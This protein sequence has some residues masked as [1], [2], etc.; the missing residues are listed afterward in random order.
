VFI[1]KK[2][3]KISVLGMGLLG[4]SVTLA[5]RRSKFTAI[6]AGYSHR[7]ST[8]EKAEALGVADV[9]Y[10]DLAECVADADIVILASP[11]CTF[12]QIFAEIGPHLKD[13]CIVTDVGST[14]IMPHIWAQKTLP[15][16]VHYVGSHPIAG[17]EK[18][19]V[20]YARDDL[21]F[22]ARCIITAKAA[23]HKPS[24]KVLQKFWAELGCNVVDLTPNMHDK[25][26][27]NVSHIPHLL[28]ASLINATDSKQMEFAGK[29]FIDTSRVASGPENV[30][31][32]IIIT[33]SS[34][35]AKGIARVVKE[36]QK[37]QKAIEDKDQNKIE[38]LLA[39]ARN[40]R[41][42][43]I[44]YKFKQKELL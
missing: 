37:M 44:E 21:L 28:A 32:D 13:G 17:S 26:F 18:R 16:R 42:A 25:I 36:L 43:L 20:E 1:L 11:I 6:S 3:R 40:K 33:N 41:A 7:A 4:A 10:S 27:C 35:A 30:W 29:G 15:K 2:L 38:K 12:E 9:I 8:C 19:G 5:V 34:N 31:S 24:I 23:T 22:G 14:K 39:R